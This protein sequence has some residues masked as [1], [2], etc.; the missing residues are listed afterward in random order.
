M[1]DGFLSVTSF[2][3][4]KKGFVSQYDLKRSNL[5]PDEGSSIHNYD[6]PNI[7]SI[8]LKSQSIPSTVEN[9][10]RRYTSPMPG[11]IPISKSKLYGEYLWPNELT[12][13]Q[14]M[15]EN[16]MTIV[17]D[18][19]LFPGRDDGGLYLIR[20]ADQASI[21]NLKDRE[22][23]HDNN[24]NN[25]R[26]FTKE[27]QKPLRITNHKKGWFYHRAVY[28]RLPPSTSAS[29]VIKNRE[30]IL[31]ARAY[32]PLFGRGR[33][34]LVWINLPSSSVSSVDNDDEWEA[35]KETVL[36]E[37]PDV[38]FET[39]DIDTSD[40]TIEIISAHFFGR[41]ITVHSLEAIAEKPY[42]KISD[43][44]V[45]DNSVGQPYGLCLASM[46]QLSHC[47][48]SCTN[49]SPEEVDEV[50]R[51]YFKEPVS[52]LV[53]SMPPN[54]T[55]SFQRVNVTGSSVTGVSSSKSLL[56][57]QLDST[58]PCREPPSVMVT[59]TSDDDDNG[60]V[61]T[62]AT[63]RIHSG[64]AS[65][66][67]K[68]VG[69]LGVESSKGKNVACGSSTQLNLHTENLASVSDV[70]SIS[71]VKTHSIQSSPFSISPSTSFTHLL[72]TTHECSYDLLSTFK[73]AVLA[74][75]GQYPRI[76]RGTSVQHQYSRRYTT[77]VSSI[78]GKNEP[79]GVGG[80]LFA[81]ELPRP[82]HSSVSRLLRN[83]SDTTSTNT[84]VLVSE[85][86]SDSDHQA[87]SDHCENIKVVSDTDQTQNQRVLFWPRHTLCTG[88]KVKGW[89][90]I[91]S[92]GAPGFP[93]VFQMPNQPPD[94]M[95]LILLAGD[96]TGSAYIFTPRTARTVEPLSLTVSKPSSSIRTMSPSLSPPPE[97]Q[98]TGV[99]SES[100]QHSERNRSSAD[101][102]SSNTH[103]NNSFNDL[104]F[105]NGKQEKMEVVS[106]CA[107]L[108]PV[109]DL[110]FEVEC[111]ATVGSAAAAPATDG[112]NSVDIFL[113][114][115]ELNQ[116]HNVTNI[117]L[118][119]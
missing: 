94:A 70:P 9:S 105:F 82:R 32:K 114:S 34:E 2:S 112:T 27:E 35:W 90:G 40:S 104:N 102:G 30:G 47:E 71:K 101:S 20:D 57:P 25:V 18:G 49:T 97:I 43:T 107:I 74:L 21:G 54:A 1:K 80:S 59:N 13:F 98:Q 29:G 36:V 15:N 5:V 41:K 83:M 55:V 93:Y 58:S 95:P 85:P 62:S 22:S 52:S 75:F 111:G 119:Y 65:S 31:T 56:E 44:Y 108:S 109:Y 96:C 4:L 113:P 81:Y 88:F 48:P 69:L 103:S 106:T 63:R 16:R 38:M 68:G 76:R 67:S 110:A 51:A 50:T 92:P 23:L 17:P 10:D 14:D 24:S 78:L 11:S 8:P 37:G 12:T 3:F 45:L 46:P 91:F 77:R 73:M 118:P 64:G 53:A 66:H 7:L 60:M 39:V 86:V 33:G 72:V 42:I 99:S 116:V 6:D 19:F 26:F 100:I 87:T 79:A 115:Y 84:R 61:L 89:G 117:T 28:V